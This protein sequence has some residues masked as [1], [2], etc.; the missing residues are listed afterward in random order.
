MLI[1]SVLLSLNQLLPLAI[2]YVLLYVLSGQQGALWRQVAMIMLALFGTLV[3]VA[4][5]PWFSEA[6]D[7]T[8]LELSQILVA[9]GVYLSALYAAVRGFSLLRIG[10]TLLF[11]T[12]LYL[13][14]YLTFLAGFWSSADSPSAL[15]VGTLLGFGICLSFSVLLYFSLNWLAD[16]FGP[17]PLYLLFALH[18][19]AKL[20]MALDTAGGMDLVAA[21]PALFDLRPWLSETSEL[22]RILTALVGFEATPSALGLG[23]YVAGAL[24]VLYFSRKNLAVKN[25]EQLS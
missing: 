15:M 1:N 21:Q 3:Y 4:M 20:V 25:R 13:S 19:S 7:Y 2:L 12:L 9:L 6:F 22:G 14:H 8:G 10:L 23:L 17:R 11:A 16:S 18:V 24:V 5:A